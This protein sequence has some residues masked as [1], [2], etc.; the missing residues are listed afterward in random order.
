MNV[1]E[2]IEL[3]ALAIEE[4]EKMK[5][6][7]QLY[8][9]LIL[10]IISVIV[11]VLCLYGINPKNMT[12]M[13]TVK[14]MDDLS[15]AHGEG[16]LQQ[17]NCFINQEE[18]AYFVIDIGEVTQ[19][20]E[21]IELHV[22]MKHPMVEDVLVDLYHSNEGTEADKVLVK[23]KLP[24]G[25]HKL[26]FI[27]D[28]GK[29]HFIR[30]YVHAPV[31]EEYTIS[32]IAMAS[33]TF[34]FKPITL[35]MTS[36]GAAILYA[37][38]IMLK[39][40]KWIHNKMSKI[41]SAWRYGQQFVNRNIIIISFIIQAG[42]L[43]YFIASARLMYVLN[44]DTL[45][46]TLAGGGNGIS[47][48]Y[49][50]YNTIHIFWGK[51]FK[52]LFSVF[53]V[54]NWITVFYL[55]IDTLAFAT[56]NFL[57]FHYV[58]KDNRFLRY[59]FCIM[60]AIAFFL[61]IEHFTFTVVAY[62]AAIAGGV[63]FA[64]IILLNIENR[65]RIG[66]VGVIAFAIASMI[67]PAVCKAILIVLGIACLL[68]L[69]KYKKK[70]GILLCFAVIMIM[71]IL[72]ASNRFVVYQS[73]VER[74]F[75]KWSAI[76]VKA[77]DAK[78]VSWEDNHTILEENGISKD[79]YDI[80]YSG[81]YVDKE[82][83]SEA[84]LN[85]LIG[86]NSVKEKYNYNIRDYF[87][88][89]FSFVGK[90]TDMHNI[91]KLIFWC[92]FVFS[93]LYVRNIDV[94]ILGLSPICVESVFVFM[95]RVPY[96]VVMPVYIFGIIIL[97][98]LC[99]K[100]SGTVIYKRY[101]G[102]ISI[103][104]MFAIYLLVKGEAAYWTIYDYD[105]QK[106]CVDTLKYM[107]KNQDKLFIPISSNLYSLELYRPVFEFAGQNGR[108]FFAGNGDAFSEPY[109]SAMENYSIKNP[110]RLIL[111]TFDNEEVLFWGISHNDIANDVY[112]GVLNYVYSET[113]KKV[114]LE[115]KE[116]IT[117]YLS[118]YAMVSVDERGN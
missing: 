63:C 34:G 81:V 20:Y 14:S 115:K 110:D 59:C 96:R 72:A 26:Y 102:A 82:V 18:N 17:G 27:D 4:I 87:Y 107:E 52:I 77:L 111:E 10:I 113:G 86:L 67:R 83:V 48:E 93:L 94:L 21:M 5:N 9:K 97:F 84:K 88:N 6:K 85:C 62:A 32:Y 109:Y 33:E 101:K 65:K 24:V 36:I 70:S 51:I 90:L 105:W 35:L 40:D 46:V 61:C 45:K 57:M 44:D 78:P 8:E 79:V 71:E 100:N 29:D 75:Y 103:V 74:D 95:N 13:K 73:E 31:G 22:D 98:I 12:V 19:N 37:I 7:T 3:F 38:C 15:S 118:V 58:I 11:S 39:L 50:G 112:T 16:Y 53:P 91:Y 116:D 30:I 1:W 55:L 49:L 114:C 76:R 2:Q 25:K 23:G 42:I 64:L 56:V 41:Y 108:C 47:S 89:Y 104:L 80:I 28:F 43:I 69:L 99:G 54:I 68:M 60:S 66:V 106:S 117:K 92:V